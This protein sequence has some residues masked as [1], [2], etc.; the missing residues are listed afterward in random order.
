MR[1]IIF[2]MTAVALLTVAGGEVALAATKVIM[3]ACKEGQNTKD[4]QTVVDQASPSLATL[5]SACSPAEEA[6]CASCLEALEGARKCKISKVTGQSAGGEK[7]W[8][9]MTCK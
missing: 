6:D 1:R 9:I 5:P 4:N 3:V 7:M 8:F 2:L